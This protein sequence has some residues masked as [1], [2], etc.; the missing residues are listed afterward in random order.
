MNGCLLH[1]GAEFDEF[2]QVGT[3]AGAGLKLEFESPKHLFASA[4]V[5]GVA[6]P[7]P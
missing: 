4:F 3:G 6:A 5:A 1:S 7:Q 2:E